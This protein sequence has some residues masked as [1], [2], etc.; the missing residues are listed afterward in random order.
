MA[1]EYKL[2]RETQRLADALYDLADMHKRKGDE[3]GALDCYR[4]LRQIVSLYA[5]NAGDVKGAQAQ[6]L[7]LEHQARLRDAM[8]R[9]GQSA[10]AGTTITV[11]PIHVKENGNAQER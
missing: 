6:L 3:E 5:K 10:I 11:E 9:R 2:G 1:K 8:V 4:E 7:Q